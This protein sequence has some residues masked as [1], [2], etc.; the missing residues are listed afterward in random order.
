MSNMDEQGM[1]RSALGGF[2]KGD[3]L[4]YID[5][6]TT[7]W[8]EER[9]QLTQEREQAAQQAAQQAEQASRAENRA[10]QL[11]GERDGLAEELTVLKAELDT[12][13]PLQQ[14]LEQ[15]REELSCSRQ[16]EQTLRQRCEALAKEAAQAKEKAESATTEMMA[17]EERLTVRGSELGACERRLEAALERIGRYERVLGRAD[18]MK[19]HLDGL[20]RPYLEETSAMADRALSDTRN[21]VDGMLEQLRSMADQLACHQNALCGTRGEIDTRLEA[22]L[23]EWLSEANGLSE[24]NSSFFRAAARLSGSPTGAGEEGRR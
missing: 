20:V 7:E 14:E 8:N 19:A 17:A 21:A 9:Q 13:R 10:A 24:E 11:T 5:R 2:H 3:V 16:Q 23:D 6:I 12:L 15:L 1:F 22:A 4:S 18:G